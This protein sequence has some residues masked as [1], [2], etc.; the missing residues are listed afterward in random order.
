[1]IIHDWNTFTSLEW[2]DL[3]SPEWAELVVLFIDSVDQSTQLRYGGNMIRTRG[4]HWVDRQA[5]YNG[6]RRRR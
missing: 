1:M 4:G 3:S 5:L 2:A 6:Y